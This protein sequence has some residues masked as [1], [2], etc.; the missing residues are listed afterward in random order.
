VAVEMK[1]IEARRFNEI[2]PLSIV[3]MARRIV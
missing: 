2:S 1:V 3:R